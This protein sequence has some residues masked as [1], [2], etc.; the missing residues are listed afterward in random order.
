[1]PLELSKVH[2]MRR[3]ER[4]GQMVL[5]RENPYIRFVAKDHYPLLIQNGAIYTDGGDKVPYKE[6]PSWFWKEARKVDLAKRQKVGLILPE[7]RPAPVKA[8]KK[9]APQKK[10]RKSSKKNGQNSGDIVED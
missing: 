9:P 5:V 8:A 1:M 6:V 3:D 2:T 7:E 10:R 4:T